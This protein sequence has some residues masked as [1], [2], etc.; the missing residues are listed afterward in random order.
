[1]RGFV[2]SLIFGR[3]KGKVIGGGCRRLVRWGGLGV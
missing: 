3:N 1:M 2:G